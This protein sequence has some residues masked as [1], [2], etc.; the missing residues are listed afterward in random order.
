MS[1]EERSCDVV[2]VGGEGGGERERERR[3]LVWFR[4]IPSF[5]AFSLWQVGF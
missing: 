1:E 4:K 5:P 2:R 3:E